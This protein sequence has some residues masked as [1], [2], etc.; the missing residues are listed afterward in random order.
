MSGHKDFRMPD[1]IGCS[2]LVPVFL[3]PVVPADTFRPVP[4]AFG[5]VGPAGLVAAALLRL[6]TL[7][8]L[9]RVTDQGFR[10]KTDEDES[11]R[12]GPRALRPLEPSLGH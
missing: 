4:S 1:V 2:E 3:H 11:N 9:E 5:P 8:M 12:A 6:R 10:T 7:E